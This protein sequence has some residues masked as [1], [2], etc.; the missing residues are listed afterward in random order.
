M[1]RSFRL[2]IL[3]GI[4]SASLAVVPPARADLTVPAEVAAAESRRIA[5]VAKAMRSAVA[6]FSVSR[7]VK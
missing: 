4:F 6:V 3:F 2:G 7:S 1:I 5:A